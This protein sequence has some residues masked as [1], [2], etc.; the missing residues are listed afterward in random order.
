[1]KL[2]FLP[3]DLLTI[4]LTFAPLQ[5]ER[6]DGSSDELHMSGHALL[7]RYFVDLPEK[8]TV[9]QRTADPP[10]AGARRTVI[11]HSL[12]L[13][14]RGL[15]F[16]LE[17]ALRAA[18]HAR[19]DP[20]LSEMRVLKKA[21]QAFDADSSGEITFDEFVAA[22]E[23]FGLCTDVHGRKGPGGTPIHVARA[24]FDYFDADGSGVRGRIILNARVLRSP[25]LPNLCSEQATACY[26]TVE[27]Y[28]TLR[29]SRSTLMRIVAELGR[30]CRRTPRAPSLPAGTQGYVLLAV[31]TVVPR[32]HRVRQTVCSCI[33]PTEPPRRESTCSLLKSQPYT[34][35]QDRVR[36]FY[37][38]GGEPRAID[39]AVRG[40]KRLR[41][42]ALAA[43]RRRAPRA[44]RPRT[45]A[46]ERAAA[47]PCDDR[48]RCMCR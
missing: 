28:R 4:L 13:M 41:P 11:G 27:L 34:A 12:S 5:P 36:R 48:A 8:A 30:V 10:A 35:Y 3:C 33:E 40:F 23:R 6:N 19:T 37:S 15:A 38:A 46:P 39:R 45:A 21:F 25:S 18:I 29:G 43:S 32:G 17:G 31:R 7:S 1:M 14:D 9:S 44:G 42:F 22:L 47:R 2:N 26:Q 24:V 16:R 20:I